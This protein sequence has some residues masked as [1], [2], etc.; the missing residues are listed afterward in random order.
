MIA[1]GMTRPKQDCC[2]KHKSHPKKYSEG[3]IVGVQEHTKSIPHI[4]QGHSPHKTY[5]NLELNVSTLY[6][7]YYLPWCEENGKIPVSA[8]CFAANTVLGFRCLSLIQ[9][10]HKD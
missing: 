7:D 6:S 4:T 10:D 8:E 3:A 1:S 2:S 5:I 9:A